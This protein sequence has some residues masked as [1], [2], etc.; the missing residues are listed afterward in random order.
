[1]PD[2]SITVL[3][4]NIGHYPQWEAPREVTKDYNRFLAKHGIK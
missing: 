2:P 4:D 3:E 1:M